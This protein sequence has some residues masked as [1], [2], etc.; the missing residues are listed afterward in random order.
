[1]IG[2][3]GKPASISNFFKAT[4]SVVQSPVRPLTPATVD[5]PAKTPKFKE[6]HPETAY[7]ISQ[8]LPKTGLVSALSGLT[9]KVL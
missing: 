2:V 7:S 6:F 4:S 3:V 5:P 1:M 8:N 9:G